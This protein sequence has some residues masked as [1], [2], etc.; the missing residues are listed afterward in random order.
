MAEVWLPVDSALQTVATKQQTAKEA[1][2]TAVQTIKDQI[3]AN[4]G[5]N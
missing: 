5:G 2:D 3:Q 4:H 1:L